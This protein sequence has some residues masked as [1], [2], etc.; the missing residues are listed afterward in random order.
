MRHATTGLCTVLAGLV[1]LLGAACTRSEPQPVCRGCNLVLISIDTLR[2]DHLACYGYERDT[3]PE[4]CRFFERGVRFDQALSQSSWTA[5]A[6]AS[7]L[8]GVY[9]SRHG[10]FSGPL[11]PKLRDA[12]NLFG[13]LQEEGYHT[14]S[15]D[16]G[17]YI[18]PVVA[19]LEPDFR[20]RV[21]LRP[22]PDGEERRRLEDWIEPALAGAAE[23]RPFF[24]F[25]HGFDLHTPYAPEGT[26][27]PTSDAR[28][29]RRARDN[30]ICRYVGLPDGSRRLVAASV[31]EKRDSRE[32]VVSLYDGEIREVD[33]ALGSFL[34]ERERRG[35]LERSVVVVTSDHG[36]EFWEH[37]SCEHVKTVYHELLR[38]PLWIRWPGSEPAVVSHPV[39]ASIDLLPT[40]LRMLGVPRPE[41]RF[42]GRDLFGPPPEAVYSEARFHYDGEQLARYSVVARGHKLVLD[43]NRGTRELY[44]LEADPGE[45]QNLAGGERPELERELALLLEPYTERAEGAR[46]RPSELDA[47]TREQ[48]RALG[49]ID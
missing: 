45:R 47:E 30:D 5:P 37:G 33:A 44:D 21:K 43:A 49:Y 32:T 26:P 42:D 19:P 23:G 27:F 3:S 10:V 16:G 18:N 12:S 29:V 15:L 31:P 34:R 46:R 1:G 20:A 24:L 25:V 22:R 28:V 38:V 13:I 9:P 35:L 7:M 4:L 36:E 39:S 17:G 2:A 6:H 14:A 11:I 48:L 41:L 8:T 40:L